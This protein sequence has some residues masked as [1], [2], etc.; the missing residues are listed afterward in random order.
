MHGAGDLTSCLNE[1][2]RLMA[3]AR[4]ALPQVRR[5]EVHFLTDLG[6]YTW[7]PTG[8]G[9]GADSL[10][11]F[12]R[13]A[14]RWGRETT[15]AVVDL[16]VAEAE[17]TAVVGFEAE[18][19]FAVAGMPVT[20]RAV[21]KH[22]GR[23]PR[24]EVTAALWVDRR[25][26]D[27]KQFDLDA[28]GE[29]TLVFDAP[30]SGLREA[31]GLT[32]EI[33][34]SPDRL[35][36][37]DRRRLVLEVKPH[38]SVLVVHEPALSPDAEFALEN[39]TSALRL[40]P[41]AE[42]VAESPVRVEQADE[43]DLRGFD[44]GEFDAVFLADV[45]RFSTET[46]ARLHDYVEAGGGLAFF[47][48]PRVDVEHYNTRLA[49]GDERILP[50]RLGPI[51][52]EPQYRLNPLK[53]EHPLLAEFRG[54]EQGGL[55]NTPVYRYFRLD[56]KSAPRSRRVLEFLNA[57]KDPLLVEETIGGGRSLVW[58]SSL[59]RSWTPM[60][61]VSPGFV[62]IVQEMLSYA[63]GGR[64]ARRSPLVGEPLEGTFRR[65]TG[66]AQVTIDLPPGAAASSTPP[67]D[68]PDQPGRGAA[69][70]ASAEVVPQ[71]E[72][73]HWT[74]ADAA[75]SGIYAANI[76]GPP[77][78]VE[79]F[80]VNVD[81]RESDPTR[82]ASNRLTDRTWS[83]VRF[84]YG[85]EV[86]DFSDAESTPIVVGSADPFHRLLLFTALGA[87]LLETWWAGRIGRRR[88]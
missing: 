7:E 2:D 81:P 5:R 3:A 73:Y 68:D 36:A 6:K 11:E 59:E 48:G 13:R 1:I 72:F 56:D 43:A 22:F 46:L 18:E 32:Y 84:A 78:S 21:V 37:D 69:A 45:R 55:F 67:A 27:E 86:R 28:G 17:N 74:F 50:A 66:T 33:E 64:A 23:N 25:K 4:D 63:I 53:Y 88:L 82:L 10:D 61:V 34:L 80:A 87:A 39:L 14:E 16:G 83:N 41:G 58:A 85:T 9:R 76:S 71:G 57:A 40:K 52:E 19:P 54:R 47:L 60:T 70:V 29:T 20:L 75:L 49:A 26:A 65:T 79:R 15:L 12:Q 42:A 8:D 44:L 77:P 62:P 31:T 24:S 51:V 38:L 35:A 30:A